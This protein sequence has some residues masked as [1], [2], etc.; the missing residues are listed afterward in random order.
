MAAALGLTF[1]PV[2]VEL[3]SYYYAFI[4]GVA[5]LA[6]QRE[7]VGRWL[8]LLTGLHP[9]RGLGPLPGHVALG[10][11][12]IHPHGGRHRGGLRLHRLDLPS[13]GP[14]NGGIVRCGM[15]RIVI[16]CYR[17]KAGKKA[18]LQS[19]IL[20]HVATLRAEGL[21]TDRE[22]ITMEAQDGTIVEVFEWVSS[23]AIESAHINAA[24]LKMWDQY[25][26]VCD[27]VPVS[28]VPEATND[29][30]RVRPHRGCPPHPARQGQGE[31]QTAAKPAAR[32]SSSSSAVLRKATG[33]KPNPAPAPRAEGWGVGGRVRRQG[34]WAAPLTRRADAPTS[35]RQPGRGEEQQ[36]VRPLP[37]AGEGG[38]E[39][40]LRE[41]V[42]VRS[43][44]GR[45]V[46]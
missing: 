20:D 38:G 24:V 44:C 22:P 12:A 33:G 45:G 19:L 8:L 40:R 13:P 35:P 1:V 7:Q 32:A 25:T 16:A 4:M 10:R 9:V 2:G 41:R 5:L 43:V 27:Y 31:G 11:R 30:R 28:Q 37:S 46:G 34:S 14:A 18:A 39:V 42:G 26:E 36:I 23:A 15:G 17:P 21:V 29:V 6:E 3:T